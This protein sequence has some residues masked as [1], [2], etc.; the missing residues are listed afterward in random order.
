MCKFTKFIRSPL[1]AEV[2]GWALPPLYL[3]TGLASPLVLVPVSAS[4]LERLAGVLTIG[5]G[6]SAASFIGSRYGST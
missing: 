4:A 6:D 3:L 5:V 1:A 2:G